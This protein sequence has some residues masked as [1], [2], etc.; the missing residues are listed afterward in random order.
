M[1]ILF[2]NNAM[3]H[4]DRHLFGGLVITIYHLSHLILPLL[5]VVDQSAFTSVL[6]MAHLISHLFMQRLVPL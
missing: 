5:E 6:Y 1:R 3:L 4:F 2:E